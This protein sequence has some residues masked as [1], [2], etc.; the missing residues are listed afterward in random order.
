M[1]S[2]SLQYSKEKSEQ[3]AQEPGS[4]GSGNASLRCS[5]SSSVDFSDE[6]DYSVRSGCVSPA[7]GDTLPWNLPRHERSKRKIHGG[8]VLDPAERAVLRIA[9]ERDRVQKK[10]FTKWIN[11]H[12][13]K[14]RK[15]I[16]DLYE[17]LR[18]GHN[19]ISLLEVLSGDKL[20]REKGRMR[21]H[22]L[23]NVQI[24]LDYLKR[25]QVKLVNI[26]NDDITDGNPKLTLGL[27]WTII[28]H[29]QISD[30]H[31]TG[32]SED[33]T[34]K[35]RL[36]LWSQQMTEGYVGVRC[37]NFTT[38]WKD[39]RLFNAIIHK[40]RPDLVDMSK[41]ST[42]TS[43]SN[44]EQA[45]NV[46]EQLGVARLLDPEDVDVTS[47]DE[48]SV[49][50]YVSTLYDVFPK[51]PEG[52][53]G[54]SANDV[55]VK[56]VEYQNM[57]NYL[58]QWIKHNVS[59]MSDRNFPSNPVELKALYLQ[60]LHFKESE[61]PLKE[62]EKT[63]IKHLYKMLEVWIEFGRIHL[64]EGYHPN[65]VEKEWGKLIV[66]MLER[67][68][69]LRPEVDRLEML[70]QIADRVK[71]DCV[72]G[73]DKLSLARASL[74]SD[75]KRFESGI[76]L[77]NE[78]EI[79]GYLLEC[80]NLLRQQV[81]DIQI[82][83]DGKFYLADQLVQRVS[84]LRDDLL[85]LRT[86]CSS[87]YS[88]GRSLST[89][90]TKM[91]ISGITQ[92]LNS[93]FSQN[94]NMGLSP[95]LTPG[96]ALSSSF[97]PAMTP[98]LTPAV[99]PGLTPAL[100]PAMT[101]GLTP[102][103]I[104]GL[105]PA[106]RVVGGSM[107]PGVLQHMKHM[108]IRKPM[109]KASLV[110][111][112]L[113][114]EEVNMKFVQDLLN[115]VDEMQ[116]Q[117]DQGEWG[118]DLPSVESHLE[119]HRNV[120]KAIEDFQMSIKEAKMS[121]IQMTHPLKQSYSDKLDLLESQYG[122]LL[123]FSKERQKHLESLHSFVSHA[124]QELIWLNEKEEEEVAFDWSDRNSSISR[125]K[126]YH[127]DL[128]RELD[129]KEGAIKSVQDQ[130]DIL[131]QQNH[132]ARLTI[133]AYKAAMQT[134]W[135]WILQL[136]YCVEQHLKE[137]V[138]YIEF[139]ND[140]KESMD[141]LK[142]LQDSITRKY[143]C[144]R[145]SSLHRLEDLIQE[146]M[147]EKEQLLQYRTTVAGLVGRA[148]SVVQLKPRNPENP[149]RT[150][151]PVKAICD[152]RQIEITIYKDD[153][154]VL[155]NNSHRAKWK[156]ISPS[157]N[158]AMVP[159]VCFT[160]PP[161]NKEAAEM[162]SRIEQLYQKVLALWHRSHVNMKSVVSWHYLM[163]DIRNIRKSTVASIKTT[164]PGEHQQVLSSLQSHFEE[165]LE[166]SEESEVF[167]VADCTQ[168]ERE[169]LGSKE[170]Y[171]EL[172][173]SAEREEHEE[174]VYNLFISEVRNFRMR[175]EA[176][177]EQLIRQIRSPLERD[178]PKAIMQRIIDQERKKAELDRLNED[179]EVLRDKCE[180][181]LRQ[182]ANSPSVPTLSSEL[183]VLT[184]SMAQV[185]S[186][187]SIYLEKLKT[188][189]LV[190][191]HSQG[192]EALVKL[193]EGKLCEEDSVNG[194]I[195][196]IDA[197][198][199]TLKQWRSEIDERRDVFHDLEDELQKA[200]SIS[201]RM[202]KTH[203][204]RDFDLDWHKEKAEQLVERWRNVHSQI[205]N[206]LRDLES[207]SKSLKYY[208]DAY[209]NLDEWSKEMETN[210]LK[211]QENQPEDSKALAELLNQQKV[212]V[213]EI[214]RKQSKID[215][216][217]K[218]S[219]QYSAGVKDYELQLM[220]YR[221]MVDSQH[222]SPV[223]RR[224]MQSSSDT[225]QQEFMDLRTRYTALVTLMTQY[226]KFASETLKRAEEDE[227]SVEEER[228][229][230]GAKVSKLL[231]WM[232][233][234][235]LDVNKNGKAVSDDKGSTESSNKSQ[236]PMEEVLSKKEQITEA[237]RSTKAILTKHSD[238]MSEEE[239]REANEQLQLLEQASSELSQ[240]SDNQTRAAE[241]EC[242]VI[243]GILDV[244][245]GAVLSVCRA[246]QNGLLD[247]CT[248][249]NL[250]EAQLITSELILPELHMCLDLEDAFKHN[251]VDEPMYKQLQDLNEAHTHVQSPRYA[252]EPLPAVAAVKDG[253]ISER[254]A[255]KIIEIQLATGGL[256]VTHTGESL[257]LE[258]AFEFGLIP[259]SLY[260]QILQR[261]N[262][263][264][265]L[266]DPNTAEKVSLIQLVQRSVV[267]EETGL[268]LMAVKS[269]SVAFRS[270]SEVSI[271]RA[272]HEGLI[273]QE[274]TL[275]LLSAQ[276]FAG[277]I[278]D[279]RTNCKLTVEEA[280]SE[281]LIDQDTATAILSHQAQHGGIVNPKSGAR[282]T[283]DEAVQCDLISSRSALLVLERHKCFMG[284]LWP[285]SG[286]ILSVS[287]SIQHEIMTEKLARELL[288]NRYKTAAFYIPENSEVLDIDTAAQNGFINACTVDFLKTIEI[289]DMLPDLDNLNDRFSSWLV[290]RELQID[291]S[292]EE[293]EVNEPSV[294]APSSSE[295]KQLFV[296]F[297]MMNSYMDPKSGRRLL[298]FDRQINKMAKVLLEMSSVDEH[299]P[300]DA[301]CYTHTG[302]LAV[303][304]IDEP[305]PETAEAS[306]SEVSTEGGHCIKTST[307]ESDSCVTGASERF[308]VATESTPY[309]VS[310]FE[311]KTNESAHEDSELTDPYT[312]TNDM[313]NSL[314]QTSIGEHISLKLNPEV[315]NQTIL[316][317]DVRNNASL[318]HGES[319]VQAKNN[320]SVVLCSKK[321]KTL[322]LLTESTH[323]EGVYDNKLDR[324]QVLSLLSEVREGGIL[325]VASG[326]RYNLDDAF[327]KGLI[328]GETVL[329]VLGLQLGMHSVKRNNTATMSILKQ[330]VS[331]S[332]ISSQ[333][334]LKIIQQQNL[335]SGFCDSSGKSISARETWETGLSTDDIGRF[336]FDLEGA[337]EDTAELVE[338]CVCS[339]SKAKT[340]HDN[341]A[342]SDEISAVKCPST[343]NDI[344]RSEEFSCLSQ[345]NSQQMNSTLDSSVILNTISNEEII[346]EAFGGRS[347]SRENLLATS[348]Q[349]DSML[350]LK[351]LGDDTITRQEKYNVET[352]AVDFTE[353]S[354]ST[355][356]TGMLTEE[357]TNLNQMTRCFDSS[358]ILNTVSYKDIS[359]ESTENAN[360]TPDEVINLSKRS[361]ELTNTLD[362]SFTL[363]IYSDEK[364]VP[365]DS[366]ETLQC[367]S[368]EHGLMRKTESSA[369]LTDLT[370]FTSSSSSSLKT[371]TSQE[372]TDEDFFE[373]C[374][375]TENEGKQIDKASN[376]L[377]TQSAKMATSLDTS[378]DSEK[379][380]T[381]GN[382]IHLSTNSKQT[383]IGLESPFLLKTA[384]DAEI[385][386]LER[387]SFEI[388]AVDFSKNR[389]SIDSAVNITEEGTHPSV[390]SK[391]IISSSDL[392]LN[393]VSDEITTEQSPS[394]EDAIKRT[395]ENIDLLTVLTEL[396]SNLYT[397]TTMKTVF[398][399]ITA[400]S[401]ENKLDTSEDEIHPLTNT[402]RMPS[403]LD[404][405]LLLATVSDDVTAEEKYTSTE[406]EIKRPDQSNVPFTNTAQMTNSLNTLLLSPLSDE[407]AD[408]KCPG[409]E[410]TVKSTPTSTQIASM[411][412]SS[413][414][415]KT[416]SD[417]Q[418]TPEGLGKK[419]HST[420][421]EMKISKD[422]KSYEIPTEKIP[423]T[424]N[425]STE[426]RTEKDTPAFTL[427]TVSEEITEATFGGKSPSTD[428]LFKTTEKTP[429]ST[430]LTKMASSLDSSFTLKTD[431]YEIHANDLSEKHSSTENTLD[432]TEET[433]DLINTIK[434]PHIIYGLDSLSTLKTD[435]TENPVLNCLNTE[436]AQKQ[437]D[438]ASSL[439]TLSQMPSS[440]NSSLTL[441]TERHKEDAFGKEYPC[442][443]N[444]V[445]RTEQASTLLTT[446]AQLNSSLD[447]SLILEIVSEETIE[448]SFGHECPSTENAGRTSE[449]T[450]S[451]PTLTQMT[452]SLDSS[453]ASLINSEEDLSKK[454][455]S[456]ENS[457]SRTEQVSPLL[458]TSP[459]LN[460]NLDPSLILET[461]SEETIKDAF[462]HE[463]PSTENAM[464][465]TEQ[466]SPL[467]MT[468]AQMKS[469]LDSSLTLETV[470]DAFGHECPGTENAVNRT[471]EVS[472]LLTASAQLNNSL[473][474][475]TFSEET[476]ED[477]FG[478][479]CSST[480]NA[481]RTSEETYLLSTLTQVSCSLNSSQASLINSDEDLSKKCPSAENSVSRTEQV[482]PLLTTSAQLNSSLDP[483]LTLEIVSEETIE[484]AF[485]R[486][487]PSTENAMNG[488]EQASPLL[489]TSAQMK[490]SLD[491]SLTLETVGDDFCPEYP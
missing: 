328:D 412:D 408:E 308:S 281:G 421:Y 346:A 191:K 322:D 362:S 258:R 437:T 359:A 367:P 267:H 407:S 292:R 73:E 450:S 320:D 472:S 443:E 260:V 386:A 185:Y 86:E 473:A 326:K 372:I 294:N 39:G 348:A 30:I 352:L 371:V 436:N 114:E 88:K 369:L 40:H 482:S 378:H 363:K 440:L 478:H 147:E 231:N 356:N 125:K 232:S 199:S 76:Q 313:L 92:S 89:E 83:L 317:S 160:V 400:D 43:R 383:S 10:T 413:F 442:T 221:A 385:T 201:D 394:T 49:I 331:L 74:Q 69:S 360:K 302:E 159:S 133:E 222:K 71:R 264:K 418:I 149:V 101:P 432:R 95:A 364:I 370:Q 158:E 154:C 189:S 145:T 395:N 393:T 60:Y 310:V 358:L 38:S 315:V 449:E 20:P 338:E 230:H 174:S 32:E 327:A 250:L 139:F 333:L 293:S 245:K 143:G 461:G 15:H 311:I 334:A 150:S 401:T 16:N 425:A 42:Q 431:K 426:E 439:L 445:N 209:S 312:K 235:K 423:I 135:S 218:Y 118:S 146:S 204:E 462:G 138:T 300:D 153:E 409:G 350:Q 126:D 477:A 366:G 180:V 468:S 287:M 225:I 347:S 238:K 105:Q 429:L 47:P 117:L 53:E 220:T 456:A 458:T 446:S 3:M 234:V 129:E 79:A 1:T 214:E 85:T 278:V 37:D 463:C 465:G 18:D 249:L 167:T 361:T 140:A 93:G 248:G 115:W 183:N 7:P 96:S 255:V 151:L 390:N 351:T 116:V 109:L 241:Q 108:Q 353:K 435:N 59:V 307:I 27:I 416:V 46:A 486:E 280:V 142:S 304:H 428:N 200:R 24:A 91:M 422:L 466:A 103:L 279:P 98:V 193:Y 65:D 379:C 21:F 172:L 452:C 298:I 303:L 104:P 397:S 444:A 64:P 384:S 187:C 137:N 296:S 420:G 414:N 67:E 374:Q 48:K 396:T 197:V 33:M 380:N 257:S 455:P 262:T 61:I 177:E 63:K 207:M 206:R 165:F 481:G 403:C 357:L 113:S 306:I 474:L 285:H 36:L 208:K 219:E 457:V 162:A 316:L 124:T 119:N 343:E 240:M 323:C 45:F 273:D 295:A 430:N 121:E 484:D 261:Q 58:N 202:F 453:H 157:G 332:Y 19:L 106:L 410:N 491:S 251:L 389:Q 161:P 460:S 254:L 469:S 434:T 335:H 236:I 28:L 339:V 215:E 110:D 318:N 489:M 223:K 122:R 349:V 152:Y 102:G 475:E 274:T 487:C 90:Q 216:C 330:A 480:E 406:I 471:E 9:D 319:S 144:D 488:T 35:E 52:L 123:N 392:T 100:T 342:D 242:E 226:V 31:V 476:I 266:I 448:D 178:E 128:M 470:G 324:D 170:Y 382:V 111:P 62:N 72:A 179:L 286:E 195:R 289:P 387:E 271:L 490:S 290:M 166:D 107:E 182:A 252:F 459:Q 454:C 77:Q 134:Q 228:K 415:L 186:M 54:I 282:M 169:V 297:L 229:E 112:S 70:Q 4:S 192:A 23:Q 132:P 212:L 41:V 399:K 26:R 168:L 84:K 337:Q 283:V 211:T 270:G 155:A 94:L 433:T 269:G 227:K 447:S 263:W 299:F 213:A 233:D 301:Q 17:D 365:E 272:M 80:E 411:L 341:K 81:V 99:T 373:K 44:L 405:S 29:F 68:K 56:W 321:A 34:A 237:L 404:S 368:T 196:S 483:S 120:H 275:R 66:A 451:L 203:N 276:L 210:Q 402:S 188:V 163:M 12:L 141:Y 309:E 11:Q 130:A 239:K 377:A 198:M 438:E 14:V 75:I 417:D 381:D 148:K 78:P 5:M 259:Q 345:N 22:R 391:Q 485:G 194:D 344:N 181:F 87:V 244:E 329:E 479:E 127:A 131:L 291:G 55:D 171:E 247:H 8:T 82:L 340:V 2:L 284:L 253:A 156:V 175:V 246:V 13:F 224:R 376:L 243:E 325:D 184:Q 265:D 25:R 398:D 277:G 173:K 205:E 375:N 441:E 256:R 336:V 427:K 6:D 190:V 217:Q 467:L 50:T 97:T 176:H 424:E 314:V 136:C 268:R 57:I 51:V 388:P 164:L 305:L 355:E 354:P 464:N 419:C 288:S